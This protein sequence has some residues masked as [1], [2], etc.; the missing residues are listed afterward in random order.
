MLVSDTFPGA[1]GKD[2]PKR[3]SPRSEQE[4]RAAWESYVDSK[5]VNGR[6]CPTPD[7]HDSGWHDDEDGSCDVCLHAVD[8]VL[9]SRGIGG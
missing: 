1:E 2:P 6:F 8:R 9:A 5:T 7:P 4:L 3:T